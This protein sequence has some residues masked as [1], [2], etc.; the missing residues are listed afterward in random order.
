MRSFARVIFLY[1]PV[2]IIP[3]DS[4]R[5]VIQNAFKYPAIAVRRS[6]VAM[7]DSVSQN[8][9]S[10]EDAPQRHEV[11]GVNRDSITAL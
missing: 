11:I 7:V 10:A 2:A 6:S 4:L 5:D 8:V 1:A 9:K 3:I